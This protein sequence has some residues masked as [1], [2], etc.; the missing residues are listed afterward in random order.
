MG[1]AMKEVWGEMDMNNQFM[2]KRSKDNVQII[3]VKII[4]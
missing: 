4:Y 2:T 3:R 1:E